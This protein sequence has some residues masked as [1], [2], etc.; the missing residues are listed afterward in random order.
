MVFSGHWSRS[1]KIHSSPKR[2]DGPHLH[3]WSERGNERMPFAPQGL[4]FVQFKWLFVVLFTKTLPC[5]CQ[6][7][8]PVWFI[9]GIFVFLC[10]LS[11]SLCFGLFVPVFECVLFLSRP[12]RYSC[13]RL[14][15][16]R[17]GFSLCSLMPEREDKSEHLGANEFR[18]CRL[19]T[20]V[21]Y[22]LNLD[23]YMIA[24]VVTR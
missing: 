23:R 4:F 22:N 5:Q 12:T 24:I 1:S 8:A 17:I 11:F 3:T 2:R 13:T 20:V 7:P 14:L 21:T 15:Y 9:A 16:L 19:I 6:Y 18:F 10:L